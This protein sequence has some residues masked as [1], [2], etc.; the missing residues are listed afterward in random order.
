MPNRSPAFDLENLPVLSV[1]ENSPAGTNVGSPIPATDPDD[2]TLTYS[3]SGGDAASFDID[4]ATGQITTIAGVTYDYEAKS[5]YSL[6]VVVEDG[7]GFRIAIVMP[8]NLT[9][10]DEPQPEFQDGASTTREVAENSGGGVNVGAPV[11]A[12]DPDDGDMVTYSL[13]GTDAASFEIGSSTGQITTKSGVTYDY[14]SKS[15]YALTVEASDGNSGTVTIAV[16]VNLTDANDLPEFQEGDSTS[17]SLAENSVAGT[18]AGLPVTATD[19]DGDTLSYIGLDGADGA[20]F[21]LDPDT[22][23]LTTVDGVTYDYET[24]SS[25]QF[26]LIVMETETNEGYLSGISVTVNLTDVDETQ[27]E[28]DSGPQQSQS[29]PEPP[30]N[31]APSFDA[32]VETTLEVAENSAAGTSVGSPITA[33]DPDEGDTVSY[34]LSGTDAASFAIDSA[35]GQITTKSGVTYDY[36]TKATYSL[37]VTASDGKGGQISTPVTVN[38]TDVNEDPAFAGSSAT[39]EVA[40]NS[41]A[42]TNVGAAVTATDPDSG[43]TLTYTL[44]GTDAA[45]FAIGSSTG[46]ITT[47]SGVTYDYETKQ[48]YSLTVEASDGNGG[49]ASIAVTVNLTDVDETP[50][51]V[52]EP[53]PPAPTPPTADAGADFNGKRGEVLTLN[54]AGTP[55]ADGSQTLTYQWSISDASDDELVTVGADFLSNADSAEATFTMPRRRDMT[56]RS[57]LDDGNWIEF[58]LTVTDG[59]AEQSTDTVKVTISGTTWTPG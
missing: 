51:V 13:S 59:D 12:T 42:G 36:E 17:R 7:N 50:P 33:T 6:T 57:A 39:R 14:E 47:K 3:L 25:Y 54:G 45:S 9:D 49:T 29:E 11:T 58:E 37:T 18:K 48:S 41:A 55:H 52:V 32:N 8:V 22:G 56:D 34:A 15:S 20:A 1:A 31:R 4:S 26:M 38:L 53:D 2:D 16:T 46:Q 40:E 35:T 24:K 27:A 44:S 19:Q 23:Q 30:A 21:A 43:N 28:G 5:R 10:V